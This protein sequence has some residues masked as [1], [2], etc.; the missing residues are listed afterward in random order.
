MRIQIFNRG[1]D[2]L[3]K[4]YHHPSGAILCTTPQRR[5]LP[6]V[7]PA[8]CGHISATVSRAQGAEILRN[9]RKEGA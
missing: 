8:S 9:W 5:A 1:G 2:A 4:R 6:R 3:I 7:I